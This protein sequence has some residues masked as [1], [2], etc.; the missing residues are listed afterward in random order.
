MRNCFFTAL[1][2]TAL[3]FFG[4]GSPMLEVYTPQLQEK[5][6]E[7]AAMKYPALEQSVILYLDHSTCVIDAV[8]NSQVFKA[9]RP[10]LGQYSDTLRL[11]KGAD[12]ES[13]PL[14]RQDNKVSEALETIKADI[15]FADIRRAVFQICSDNQQAILITDCEALAN[16]RFLDL[17]PFMSEPFRNWIEAGH[18][19]YIL[20]EP[21]REKYKGNIYDKKRFYFIFS[22]DRMEAPISHNL[23]NEVQLLL[24]DSLCNLFK[25]TNS[26]ISVRREGKNMV[27]EDLTFTVEDHSGFEY[28]EISDDWR[29]IREYVM[30]LDEYGEPLPEEKPVPLIKNLIFNDGE[31]YLI[32]NVQIVATNITSRYLALEDNTITVKDIDISDG[33][34]LDKKAL[35][36]H[37]FNVM[38]TDKIFTDGYLDNGF[39]G[40]LVRLDFVITNVSLKSYDPAMFEWQSIW[41]PNTAICVS[42]SID[43]ALR[44]VKVVPTC[45]NRKVIHTVFL[46][47]E[48]YK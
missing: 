44:D 9:L 43:N 14:D 3:A 37:K 32:G 36:S 40:N 11:I 30:K 47:T 22:D 25:L 23:L 20:T 19:I 48:S 6:Y 27:A 39:G 4:C 24:Q 17:E 45:S 5:I 7:P 10:N 12:F 34:M 35:Q 1:A 18:T 28:V 2:F 26:D 16:G 15:P 41:S 38:L 21:Y 29:S 31:N 13:I 8:Q 46:K 42:K 33:F